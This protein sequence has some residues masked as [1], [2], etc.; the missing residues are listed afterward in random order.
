M[1]GEATLTLT[2]GTIDGSGTFTATCSG[3]VD[4]AADTSPDVAVSYKVIPPQTAIGSVIDDIE[5]LLALGI[6]NDGLTN[7]LTTKLELARKMLRGSDF[8]QRA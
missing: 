7:S 4:F 8:T 3:A 5:K 2:G 6:L 1:L